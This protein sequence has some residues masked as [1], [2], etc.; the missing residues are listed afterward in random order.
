M[1]PNSM[2]IGVVLFICSSEKNISIKVQEQLYSVM[3]RLRLL[4]IFQWQQEK[5]KPIKDTIS[6]NNLRLL[7]VDQGGSN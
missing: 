7:Y 2:T 6:Q 3:V 4:L 5:L 1:C